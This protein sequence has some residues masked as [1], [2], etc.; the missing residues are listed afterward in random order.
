MEEAFR[1]RSAAGRV[2]TPRDVDGSLLRAVVNAGV[3]VQVLFAMGVIGMALTTDDSCRVSRQPGIVVKA[4]W[5]SL[6]CRP[7]SVG[8]RAMPR[9]LTCH[10]AG[11]VLVMLCLRDDSPQGGD[12]LRRAEC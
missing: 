4:I 1:A 11:A 10:L 5:R 2:I 3:P 7:S 9:R 6:S 12:G 8:F